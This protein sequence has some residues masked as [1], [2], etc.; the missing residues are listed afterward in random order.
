M[1]LEKFLHFRRTVF[2]QKHS[3]VKSWLHLFA[4]AEQLY[5]LVKLHLANDLEVPFFFCF[6]KA[7]ILVFKGSMHLVLK[8]LCI[9][10]F[11]YVSLKQP[12]QLKWPKMLV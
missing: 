9:Y 4:T 8:C 3:H 7:D 6:D 11:I 1:L 10:L 12:K 5:C 2:V